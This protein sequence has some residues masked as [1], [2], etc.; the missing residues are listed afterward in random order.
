MSDIKYETPGEYV[1]RTGSAR[2]DSAP[3]SIV[4]EGTLPTPAD[5]LAG[6]EFPQETCHLRIFK[7]LGRLELHVHDVD[8][9]TEHVIGG[10]LKRD[11]VLDRFCLNTEERWTNQEFLAF[12]KTMKVVIS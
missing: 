9:F 1:I 11:G 4:L 8:P 3:K 2:E 7:D 10:S 6:K 12:I 5:F